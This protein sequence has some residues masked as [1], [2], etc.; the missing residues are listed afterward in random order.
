MPQE[1]ATAAMIVKSGAAVMLQKPSD[2][3]PVI[4]RMIEDSKHY[5]SLRA[6]TITLAIPNAT[7]RIVEEIVS[8]IPEQATANAE[9][10]AERAA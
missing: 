10:L 6:A 4:R 5:A 1:A 7:R 9:A 8:L 3:V 2:V